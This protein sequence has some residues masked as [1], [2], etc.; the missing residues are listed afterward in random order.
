[1]MGRKAAFELQIGQG[2]CSDATTALLPAVTAIYRFAKVHLKMLLKVTML[3]TRRALSTN[4]ARGASDQC[5]AVD[6]QFYFMIPRDDS[7]FVPQVS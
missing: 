7:D 6:Y 5:N 3:D 1:M 4:L 2:Y